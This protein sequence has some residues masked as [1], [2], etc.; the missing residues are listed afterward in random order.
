MCLVSQVLSDLYSSVIPTPPHAHENQHSQVN[1][2]E[3]IKVLAEGD[4]TGDLNIE[5]EAGEDR[6]ADAKKAIE[7]ITQVMA[8]VQ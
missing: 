3:F 6:I 8:D 4:Y 7:R 5:R 2:F 1:W